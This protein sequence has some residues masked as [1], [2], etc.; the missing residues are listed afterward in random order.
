VPTI[1]SLAAFAAASVALLVIPGPAVLY[2]INRSV[3][4]GRAVG[5]AAVAGLE[6]GNFVHVLGATV[7]LSTLLAASAAAF[8][9]VKLLG[10]GYLVFVGVRTLV[11]RPDAIGTGAESVALGRA[12]RQGVI[13]NTF[14][15]KVALF[16]L[17]LL[18]QFIDADRG[19]TAVQSLVLGS[20][21]VALGFVTDGLYALT[22]SGLRDVLLR[23]RALPFIRRWIAGSVFV[24]LGLIAATA[25]RS[26]S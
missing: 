18:P 13:V 3:A 11:R 10:A 16:F 17:S 15:P 8:N 5:L 24:G 20:T 14:N 6:T 19:T 7:G 25:R 26:T 23:G 12:F 21:F 2:I 22:A 1:A 4:D 9:V